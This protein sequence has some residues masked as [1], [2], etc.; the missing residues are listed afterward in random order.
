MTPLRARRQRLGWTKTQLD[1][2]LR[3]A[4]KAR[5]E[6]LPQPASLGRQ[7]SRWENG[8][9]PVGEFYQRLFCDV[10]GCSPTELG[11]IEPTDVPEPESFEDLAVEL[12]RASSVDAE[13]AK[14]LQAQT[15]SIRQLDA[16]QGAQLIREQMRAHIAHIEE[17]NH[18][19]VRPGVRSMLAKVLADASALAGWQALDVGTPRESW[20]H[21]ERA[22]SAAR[23]AEDSSLLAFATVEQAYVV[24]DLGDAEQ[25]A[26]LV[27]HARHQSAGAVPALM[28]TWLTAAQAE[29]A[30]AGGDADA[31]HLAL[32]QATDLLP[33]EPDDSLPYLVLSETHLARWRGNCLARLG[34]ENAIDELDR[35][36]PAVT[37][38]YARA[39]AGVRIDLATALL[40]HGEHRSVEEHLHVARILVGRTGS[41]RQKRRIESLTGNKEQR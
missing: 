17:L 39:E 38:T 34:D 14:L 8:H 13:V 32:D 28:Q 35:G 11:F 33:A 10:Y 30:T 12:A 31:A 2:R 37:G 36:L 7:V 26:E 3:H 5:G 1:A 22:K 41:L 15:D 27:Q 6:T 20:E 16:L 21:F 9:A 25:A 40:V 29:M 23:E 18:H 4:A 24:L 19:A